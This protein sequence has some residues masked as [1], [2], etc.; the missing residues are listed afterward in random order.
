MGRGDAPLSPGGRDPAVYADDLAKTLELY[1]VKVIEQHAAALS[2]HSR[3][4]DACITAHSVRDAVVFD[5]AHQPTLSI[6]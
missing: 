2:R 1:V 6:Q 3:T 4:S 5:L